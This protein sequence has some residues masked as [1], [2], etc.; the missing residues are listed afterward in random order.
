MAGAVP[1]SV[2]CPFVS[3]VRA[4]GRWIFTNPATDTQVEIDPPTPNQLVAIAKHQPSPDEDVAA[5]RRSLGFEAQPGPWMRLA[6]LARTLPASDP[7]FDVCGFLCLRWVSQFVDYGEQ[8]VLRSDRRR[9]RR[10]AEGSA[11]PPPK[12]EHEGRAL[13]LPHPAF[14]D[15]TTDTDRIAHLLYF[16]FGRIRRGRFLAQEVEHRAVPSQGARHPLQAYVEVCTDDLLEPGL[17]HYDG[18][19]HRL[20]RLAAMDRR[21]PPGTRI[22]MTAR[23]QRYQW[24]YR[25]KWIF[26]DLYHEVGH[27][28][29]NLELVAA[30]LGLDV[31]P[32]RHRPPDSLTARTEPLIEDVLDAYCVDTTARAT[33]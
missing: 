6:E 7:M 26:K 24:R 17:Y 2:P 32:C 25:D 30:D 22:W 4:G 14:G 18:A 11:P 20:V 29:G 1:V 5:M 12:F 15:P 33:K 9:M 13:H 28:R 27:V 3:L 19:Q 23:L 16:S 10:Y 31:R 8:D 21:R